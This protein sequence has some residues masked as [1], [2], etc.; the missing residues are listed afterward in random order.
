MRCALLS[1]LLCLLATRCLAEKV[2][3][4]FDDLP[5]NGTLPAGVTEVDVVKR[6]LPILRAHKA[7]PVFGFIN[8]RKLEGNPTGAEALR[9]W[10][11]GGQRVGNHTYA[12]TDLTR[13]VPEEFARDIVQNEPA[14]LLLSPRDDWHWFRYPYLHEG[15]T[16]EKRGAARAILSQR[17]YRIAQVTLDYEDYLW[18]SAYARCVD[19]Q[20][21][22]SIEW[23]HKSYLETASAYLDANREMARRVF[24]REINHVLLLHLG[25]FSETILPPLFDLLRRKDFRLTTLEDAQSDPVYLTDPNFAH[26]NTGTLVE[27][28]MDARRLEY[29]P[30]PAKPRKEVDAACR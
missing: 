14:L 26:T 8:A 3:L 25:A 19:K 30:V 20:D 4:T 29:A 27:Q 2:A 13:T 24:G 1:M 6:V 28:H 23:L 7:A 11:A 16:L 18:N 21:T 15:D 22:Q 12:H 17:G 10:V 5:L 9:L